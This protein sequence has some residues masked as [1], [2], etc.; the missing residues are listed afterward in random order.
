MRKIACSCCRYSASWVVFDSV[1][2][3]DSCRYLVVDWFHKHDLPL[4]CKH[5]FLGQ[6]MNV[7]HKMIRVKVADSEICS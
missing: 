1:V 6:F 5:P 7:N 4:D 2:L 3:C